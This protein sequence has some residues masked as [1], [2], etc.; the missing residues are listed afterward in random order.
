MA[1]ADDVQSLIVA[2]LVRIKQSTIGKTT[3][4]GFI[5]RRFVEL[6]LADTVPDHSKLWRF[7]NK[8]NKENLREKLIAKIDE[9]LSEKSLYVKSGEI[10]IVDAS[11]IQST[12]IVQ[13][14]A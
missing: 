9:Q 13:I 6:S 4:T 14:K 8:L 1:T 7:R 5:I 11:V 12:E 3:C 2:V 10:N